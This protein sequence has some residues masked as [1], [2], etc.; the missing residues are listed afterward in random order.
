[1]NHKLS[2]QLFINPN[3]FPLDVAGI[4]AELGTKQLKPVRRFNK[5]VGYLLCSRNV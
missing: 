3:T 5:D 1:M 2:F 4:K